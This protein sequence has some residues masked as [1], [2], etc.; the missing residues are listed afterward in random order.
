MNS[1]RLVETQQQ[2]IAGNSTLDSQ[3]QA[4]DTKEASRR[5]L[6]EITEQM[7]QRQKKMNNDFQSFIQQ[8]QQEIHKLQS[9]DVNSE[10]N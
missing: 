1:S 9:L 4:Q 10:S 5:E 8:K 2:Q 7:Q 3:A 6:N